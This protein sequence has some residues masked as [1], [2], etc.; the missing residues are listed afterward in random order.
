MIK[1]QTFMQ[2]LSL[3]VGCLY[4][5]VLEFLFCSGSTQCRQN[6]SSPVVKCVCLC[7]LFSFRLS[8]S[9]M[10][11]MWTCLWIQLQKFLSTSLEDITQWPWVLEWLFDMMATTSWTSKSL[12]RMS[13]ATSKRIFQNISLNFFFNISP[14]YS[15][16]ITREYNIKILE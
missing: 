13:K 12:Q 2:N 8:P 11:P 6:S 4:E 3:P 1:V 9:S 5:V 16:C 7:P 14:F 10:E 15:R